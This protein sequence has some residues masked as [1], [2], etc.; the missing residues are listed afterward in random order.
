MTVEPTLTEQAP[1]LLAEAERHSWG[2]RAAQRI[3]PILHPDLAR[4]L[5]RYAGVSV[6]STIVSVTVLAILVGAIGWQPGWSN[7]VAVG[8]ATIPSFELN[9]RWVWR[10]AG[11]RSA[12]KEVVPFF[13][14]SFAGL[15]IS[16]T[17]VHYAGHWATDAGWSRAARTVV[18]EF[19]SLAGFGILWIA[20]FVLLDRVLFKAKEHTHR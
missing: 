7:L 5:G 11:P 6:I 3:A 18:V 1:E 16:T 20:Q 10:K 13:A 2:V 12:H 14:F 4:K 9:R 15:A 19:A 17:L 8:I